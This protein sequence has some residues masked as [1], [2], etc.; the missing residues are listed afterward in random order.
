MIDVPWLNQVAGDPEV[1]LSFFNDGKGEKK[2]STE[3]IDWF[4]RGKITTCVRPW[5]QLIFVK[6]IAWTRGLKGLREGKKKKTNSLGIQMKP[7]WIWTG[8]E[9]SVWDF[10]GWW[11]LWGHLKYYKYKS[12]ACYT[13]QRA[14]SGGKLLPV[15][16]KMCDTP[17]F[18]GFLVGISLQGLLILKSLPSRMPELLQKEEIPSV[19][20]PLIRID[21]P[22]S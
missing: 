11:W 5:L 15:S 1:A 2:H 8:R 9:S 21:E 14:G 3:R 22:D 18:S 7:L 19:I 17:D 4:I 20:P 12:W 16:N 10:Q 6:L 13:K